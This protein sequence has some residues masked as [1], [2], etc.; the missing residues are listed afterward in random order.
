M[1]AQETTDTAEPV[2]GAQEHVRWVRGGAATPSAASGTVRLREPAG[3]PEGLPVTT[4]QSWPHLRSGV[5]DWTHLSPSRTSGAG[6][7]EGC[8]S[9]A[10]IS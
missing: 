7:G 1:R 8:H 5:R 9:A 10:P 2:R 3:R 4:L 6:G